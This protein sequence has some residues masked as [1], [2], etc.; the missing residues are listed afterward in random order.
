TELVVRPERAVEEQ[1]IRSAGDS[2]HGVIHRP[3][4]RDVGER[5][6][7]ALIREPQADVEGLSRRGAGV[8]RRAP[9]HRRRGA[10][11]PEWA[12]SAVGEGDRTALLEG[13]R[14]DT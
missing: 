6:A 10:A 11:D 13:P 14:V 2:P 5:S 8:A 7:G 1:K 9:G 4:R 3:G 12:A